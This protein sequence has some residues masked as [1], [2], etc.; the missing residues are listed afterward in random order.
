[1]GIST[2]DSVEVDTGGETLPNSFLAYLS[3]VEKIGLDYGKQWFDS[4]IRR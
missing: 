1:M 3:T 2:G 4:K